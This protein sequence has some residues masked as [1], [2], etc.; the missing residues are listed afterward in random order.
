MPSYY[1][2][3]LSPLLLRKSALNPTRPHS[4]LHRNQVRTWLFR[5][6][7]WTA[8]RFPGT[9]HHSNISTNDFVAIAVA[10][11]CIL[12]GWTK[13]PWGLRCCI[14]ICVV[15]LVNWVLGLSYC[16]I[17]GGDAPPVDWHNYLAAS[18]AVLVEEVGTVWGKRLVKPRRQ[19]IIGV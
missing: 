2:T 16:A 17:D 19:F 12:T 10:T 18:L 4:Q 14:F 8:G 15:V 6:S 11:N 1:K 13:N 9:R 7:G 5:D 3:R